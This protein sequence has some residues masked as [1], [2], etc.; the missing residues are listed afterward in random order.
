MLADLFNFKSPRDPAEYDH[1]FI[2][3]VHVARP[4]PRNPRVERFL[5][6]CWVLIAIKHVAV[7]W[8][9]HHYRVP[10][11]QLWVNA[12]TWLL[13]VVATLLYYKSE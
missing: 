8:L 4:T 3:E 10:F 1:A 13:G 5:L 2:A 7:I 12:P 11:H 6:V 9:V